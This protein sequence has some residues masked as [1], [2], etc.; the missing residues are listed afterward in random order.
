M[1]ATY[2]PALLRALVRVARRSVHLAV[3]LE[4]I[5]EQFAIMYWNQVVVHHL[6]Q[7]AVLTKEA[8]IIRVLRSAAEKYGVR[9][10]SDL[11][12]NGRAAL[13]KSMARILRINV[14]A[15]F[16]SS[17]PASMPALYAWSK[18]EAFILLS[19]E[20][21]AFLRRHGQVLE[22]IANYEWAEFLEICNR[23][24]PRVIQKVSGEAKRKSLQRYLR[25]LLADGE[26]ACFYCR[27]K[28][29]GFNGPVV[30]HVIPWSFVLEDSL[31]DLVLCCVPCN[32]AKS[33]W[34]PAREYLER[35]IER[36]AVIQK[37]EL[38]SGISLH[39]DLEQVPKLFE[40]AVAGEWPRFWAPASAGIAAQS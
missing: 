12:E 28:F 7:A 6:R 13:R 24:A 5:G 1:S 25:V 11:P 29:D 2:K 23:F 19:K 3:P 17:K 37:R 39:A 31:W 33:D 34:L 16:H 8:E 32:S 9:A 30:D 36:N 14:L 35:L 15:A 22:L 10:Y 18:D 26:R 27:R 21:H 4:T 20:S 38:P 40:A